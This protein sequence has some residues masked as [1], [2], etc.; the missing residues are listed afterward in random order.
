MKRWILLQYDLTPEILVQNK[1]T[2]YSIN[3][4]NSIDNART[5]KLR[6]RWEKQRQNSRWNKNMKEIEIKGWRRKKA[7]D[8]KKLDE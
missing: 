4:R 7:N 2:K 5:D 8:V 3:H 6:N 1:I